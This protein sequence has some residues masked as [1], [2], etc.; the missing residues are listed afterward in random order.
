MQ[1]ALS[2][3]SIIIFIIQY[4]L[5]TNETTERTQNE[6]EAQWSCISAYANTSQSFA[7]HEHDVEEGGNH[8]TGVN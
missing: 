6:L 5:S 1:V 4:A 2:A 8:P 7:R 3:E